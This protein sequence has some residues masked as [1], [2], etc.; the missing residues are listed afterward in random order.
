M[1][2]WLYR[3]FK[4][5]IV[6][7][8]LAA[9]VP[10]V[11]IAALQHDQVRS[12]AVQRILDEVNEPLAGAV[13]VERIDGTLLGHARL[14]DV[15]VFDGRGNLAAHGEAIDVDFHLFPLLGG[16]VAVD[17][18][19]MERP[20]I[21]VRFYEDETLNWQ[22]VTEPVVDPEPTE[23]FE[24]P[25]HI[26][27]IDIRDGAVVY[28]DETTV[29]D[30]EIEDLTGWR[31]ATIEDLNAATD[32][33]D[34]RERMAQRFE[35]ATT[36][37]LAGARAPI[38]LWFT[39]LAFAGEFQMFK[40]DIEAHI[41]HIGADVHGDIV[42]EPLA[43]SFSD[44]DVSMGATT[45]ITEI[46]DVELGRWLRARDLSYGMIFSASAQDDA[47]G[48]PVDAEGFEQIFVDLG[49]WTLKEE[50]F[51]WATPD[52]VTVAAPLQLEGQL[53]IDPTRADIVG[54]LNRDKAAEA[55]EVALRIR[56]YTGPQPHYEIGVQ[57]P[58][59]EPAQW[60][61]QPRFVPFRSSVQLRG[62][63]SG[64]DPDEVQAALRLRL[65]ETLVDDTYE[66]DFAYAE[67]DIDS[68]VVDAPRITTLSPYLDLHASARFDVDGTAQLRART[69]ADDAQAE[70]A[71][72]FSDVR[73][74]RADLQLDI[75][76]NF[77]PDVDEIAESIADVDASATWDLSDVLVEELQIDHSSG[78]ASLFAERIAVGS[79]RYRGN[80]AINARGSGVGFDQYRIGTFAVEDRAT[81]TIAPNAGEPMEMLQRFDNDATIGIGNLSTPDVRASRIDLELPGRIDPDRRAFHADLSADIEALRADGLSI[82]QLHTE[83]DTSLHLSSDWPPLDRLEADV[84]AHLQHVNAQG[85]TVEEAD[86]EFDTDLQLRRNRTGL[87]MVRQIQLRATGTA[88]ELAAPE[89]EATGERL[90]FAT[91]IEGPPDDPVGNMRASLEEFAVGDEQFAGLLADVTFH[92]ELR[93][94]RLDV[95]LRRNDD[96]RYQ[97]GVDV[98]FQPH[99]EAF[100]LSNIEITTD[101]AAW[102]TTPA[103]RLRWTGERIEA[104]HFLLE[105]R[106]QALFADGHFHPDVDQDL[107]MALTLDFEEFIDGLYLHPLIPTI[108]GELDAELTLRGT[109][110]RPR[111]ELE[112]ALVDFRFMDIFGPLS[113]EVAASYRDEQLRVRHLEA[114][115]FY[116]EIFE[117]SGVFPVAFDMEGHTEVFA[118]RNSELEVRIFPQEL[119][120]FHEPIPLLNLYGIDGTVALDLDWTGRLEDPRIDLD[121]TVDDFQFQGEVGDDFVNVRNVDFITRLQYHSTAV[122]GDGL[123]LSTDLNWEED[124]IA[125]LVATTEF[126]I[127][128]WIIAATEGNETQW[129]WHRELLEMPVAL[130][131]LVPSFDLER[132]PV[133]RLRDHELAGIADIDI[134]LWGTI[135]DPRGDIDV[136]FDD[137]GWRHFG[138]DDTT[139]HFRD[140]SLRFDADIHDQQA[141]IE[142]MSV[143]WADDELFS[144]HGTVPLPLPTLLAGEPVA[145]LPLDFEWEFP[146][147]SIARF[148][149][150]DYS[151]ARIQGSIAASL[152]LGGS[153][154]APEFTAQAGIFDTRLGDGSDGSVHLE[155]AGADDVVNVDGALSRNEKPVLDITGRAPVR[156]DLVALTTGADWQ[157]PGD[158]HLDVESEDVALEDVLPTQLLTSYVLEPE[159]LLSVELR[160]RGQ[161]EQPSVSGF[162]ALSDGAVTLPEFGRGFANINGRIDID[163]EELRIEHFEVHDGPSSVELS[164]AVEH[165]L[166]IPEELDLELAADQFNLVGLGTD[167][168][169]FV[170]ADADVTG[171]LFGD[172]GEV[173]IQVS[174]LEV[175]LTDEWDRALHDTTLDPDIIIVDED[176]HRARPAAQLLDDDPDDVDGLF[177]VINIDLGRNSW[178]RHPAGDVNFHADLSAEL[179]GRIVAVTGSVDLIRGDLEFL[180]RR[181]DIQP[182]DITFTGEVPPNPRLRIEA[183]HLLDRVIED[184]LGPASVGEPRIMINVGGT[185]EQPR[186]QLQSDPG[187]TDTEILFVLMTGR[188]PD[189]TDVGRDEGVAA[190]ALSAVSG[191]FLGMLQDELAG[192]VPIDVL[193][194]EPGDAGVRGGRVELGTYLTNDFFFSYRHQFGADEDIAANIFRLEYHFLPRWMV[195]AVYTDR[196]EGEFNLFWDAL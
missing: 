31:A 115:I 141:Q 67:A 19:V 150:I 71:A 30:A 178:A 24:W 68:G 151:L 191:V 109:S 79:D 36:A 46:N 74:T 1:K 60:I 116:E 114:A 26:A 110:A 21:G 72:E 152:Q 154:R 63:G 47:A 155:V 95:D 45:M 3:F 188:P 12:V 163:D 175:V 185:A 27:D 51:R 23:P 69:T 190:Q 123:E 177:L 11:V 59:L 54:Q 100:E 173:D 187:M 49:R 183:H 106:D 113:T 133:E 28:A 130:R 90:E 52:D 118:D 98:D 57:A 41:G 32:G 192:T 105:N 194:L 103:A 84:T 18:V 193:R 17:R 186:L 97:A 136:A 7:A 162:L 5:L 174:D 44:V 35:P 70:R 167:F 135:E 4:A 33:A 81:A 2:R 147:R 138:D 184:A 76:A 149:A 134:D 77:D 189:R 48:E 104:D 94:G 156:L 75:D 22:T 58:Q 87:D 92:E 171:H 125:E 196:N 129:H 160:V 15:R 166:L 29:I 88:T 39:S 153:L 86:I 158:L 170:T 122:G 107:R 176:R 195:E 108:E 10:L 180:G 9:T 169:L 93:Q 43:A 99:Y 96:E 181:F 14:H 85:L 73:A 143:T 117:L 13:S 42:P 8:V 142:Q 126:P 168:P 37:T 62:T 128:E 101:D 64:F 111:A 91:S 145:D 148:S 182:S 120:R 165:T 140:F 132:I 16:A 119:R 80:Y 102:A 112:A 40:E 89:W 34:L 121:L 38:A 179:T 78:S 6:V 124:P 53:A 139:R 159:G 20:T 131:L 50:L 172:P 65:D 83:A 61:S 146:E 157:L 55:I 164:G 56:D 25:V 161:W 127:E 82:Q 66:I 137:M 144:G